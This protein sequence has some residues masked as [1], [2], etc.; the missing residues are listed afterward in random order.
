MKTWLG[1][2]MWGSRTRPGGLESMGSGLAASV[3]PVRSEVS[4]HCCP[5]L[6]LIDV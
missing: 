5:N 2:Q 1:R 3:L 4:S 6:H